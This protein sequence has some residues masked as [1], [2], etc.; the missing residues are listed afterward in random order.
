MKRLIVLLSVAMSVNCSPSGDD[1]NSPAAQTPAKNDE[2]V[3]Q[4]QTDALQ[5][6]R[7]AE[8]L[9][10]DTQLQRKQQIDDAIPPR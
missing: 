7:D 9:L 3:W 10:E 6:A 4:E 8:K 1:A 5:K 2:H